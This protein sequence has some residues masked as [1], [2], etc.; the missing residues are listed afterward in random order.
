[1]INAIIVDDER[2]ARIEL[3]HLLKI[4]KEINIVALCANKKEVDETLKTQQV[5]LMFL[6]INMPE[7]N[8]FELLET[9][10]ETPDVIFVTAYDEY[11]VNA[12]EVNAL[13]YLLKPV[14]PERLTQTIEKY[15]SNR[16]TS[17]IRNKEQNLTLESQIFIKDG[18]KC[19]FVEL[20]NIRYFQS[21]GN[22]IRVYFENQKPLILN[23]LNK[24]EEKLDSKYFFRAN[25]KHIINLKWIDKVEPWFNGGLQ[26]VLKS[27][28]KIEISRRQSSKFKEQLSI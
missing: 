21:E 7:K 6:D 17:N 3:E 2:L 22:Y 25:R 10:E 19:W 4:H 5:D 15:I 14:D 12:F 24:L 18:Q 23:S 27:G 8:G 1:M 28:E 11:A 16:K 26:A 13:D 9:I 20:K